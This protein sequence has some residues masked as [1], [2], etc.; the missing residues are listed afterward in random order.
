[1]ETILVTGAFGNVGQS[2]L[3]ALAERPVAVRAFDVDNAV[4]RR[5]A[6]ARPAGTEVLWGDLRDSAAVVRAVRGV[7]AVIHLAAIIPPLAN[8]FPELARAV[9]VDGTANL[10]AA[11]A[12]EPSPP[13]LV[14]SSS[15]ATYGDRVED[16]FIKVDDPLC[17]CADDEYARHK[18]ACEGLIRQSGLNWVICRL[19]YI[20]WRKKLALDPLMF[21]MP[22]ATR[23]EVCHTLDTGL[24]LANAAFCDEAIAGTFNLAGGESCRT[25]YRTY[26]DRMLRSFGLGG[27]RF[28]PDAAFSRTGYHCGWMDTNE[29]QRLLRFQHHNLDFYYDEVRREAG[30]LKGLISLFRP[31]VQAAIRGRSSYLRLAGQTLG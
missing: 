8:R 17:P 6:R 3:A 16:W 12:D 30:P 7:S 18:V 24:A 22:L 20:V 15:V 9:N 25:D 13:R 29:A 27:A 10:L 26:L 31:L 1:M 2:T 19:S 28:L 21:R 14:F 4:N 11:M 5:R 23:L